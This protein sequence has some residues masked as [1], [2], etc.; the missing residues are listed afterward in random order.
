MY[1]LVRRLAVA[2]AG[3]VA[4]VQPAAAQQRALLDSAGIAQRFAVEK[5]LESVAV[6]DRK[7]MVPMRDGIRLATDIYRPKNATGK[8][9]TIFVRT[10]YNFNFWDVRNSAPRDMTDDPRCGQARLCVRRAER[11]RAT[12]S[13]RATTTS[14]GRRARTATT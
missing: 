8:V 6:I 2:A 9:P 11:A 10:P 4:A 7:V 5:E 14:S 13:P 3:V 1:R 12:S